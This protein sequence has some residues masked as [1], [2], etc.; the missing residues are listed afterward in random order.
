MLHAPFAAVDRVS[1]I[2]SVALLILAA[3]GGAK[4]L[5][6]SE[7]SN[8]TV[9]TDE[10]VFTV[11]SNPPEIRSSSAPAQAAA[12]RLLTEGTF[13]SK[14][15]GELLLLASGDTVFKPR[16]TA[17]SDLTEPLVLLPNLLTQR[18]ETSLSSGQETLGSSAGGGS[19]VG[20]HANASVSGEV[21]VY[22]SKMYLLPSAYSLRVESSSPPAP[23]TSP[24]ATGKSA[25][26]LEK[27]APKATTPKPATPTS[28]PGAPAKTGTDAK[29]P[30][31]STPQAPTSSANDPRVEDLIREL[32]ARRSIPRALDPATPASAPGAG[33]PT[34]PDAGRDAATPRRDA[35][36]EGTVI[37]GRRGRVI[38]AAGGG[39]IFVPDAGARNAQASAADQP[40]GL[41]PCRLLETIESRGGGALPGEGRGDQVQ[42]RISG[43]VVVFRGRNYLLP[44]LAQVLPQTDIT[45]LQ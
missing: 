40:M 30:S 34:T 9:T 14:L 37:D 35:A 6:Q 4:A 33:A 11:R 18:L 42:F 13:V 1:A 31:A 27:P 26:P 17:A 44:T 45:P 23:D 43:R 3:S 21:F 36:P 10:R 28:A 24:A 39:L 12:A 7:P 19:I 38:R 29:A 22:R 41:L 2:A 16:A 20:R 32:E 25:D 8:P 15:E 5:G